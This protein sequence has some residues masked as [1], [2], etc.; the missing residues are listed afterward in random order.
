[1]TCHSL[2]VLD[3]PEQLPFTYRVAVRVKASEWVSDDYCFLTAVSETSTRDST[4]VRSTKDIKVVVAVMALIGNEIISD[5]I[6]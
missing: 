6:G 1:M 2:R 5:I 4:I 3:H